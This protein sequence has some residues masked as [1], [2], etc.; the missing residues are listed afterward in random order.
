MHG[1]R[2]GKDSGLQASRHEAIALPDRSVPSLLSAAFVCRN[3]RD[4]LLPPADLSADDR[5]CALAGNLSSCYRLPHGVPT[6]LDRPN[7][8]PAEW[9]GQRTAVRG[10]FGAESRSFLPA[11]PSTLFLI[12]VGYNRAAALGGH[13]CVFLPTVLRAAVPEGKGVPCLR[14]IILIICPGIPAAM[15]KLVHFW[16]FW[17]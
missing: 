6:L 17:R 15:L 12:P 8:E 5:G 3:A 7:P 4:G 11:S 10:R 14:F 13:A 1:S 16:S 9:L 2:H